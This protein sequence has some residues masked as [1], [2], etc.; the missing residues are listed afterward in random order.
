[1]AIKSLFLLLASIP[2]LK[3]P[4]FQMNTEHQNVLYS[5]KSRFQAFG[6]QMFTVFLVEEVKSR[7]ESNIPLKLGNDWRKALIFS[8]FSII[9]LVFVFCAID[10]CGHGPLQHLALKL[11]RPGSAMRCRWRLKLCPVRTN[12]V[13]QGS[14][15]CH[16]SCHTVLDPQKSDQVFNLKVDENLNHS[17]SKCS[18]I[19]V[20]RKNAKFGY[21]IFEFFYLNFL[22]IELK[23]FIFTY[24]QILR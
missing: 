2:L 6:I 13:W 4:Y 11:E 19:F 12:V 16:G 7:Y 24:C 5:D 10:F 8:M 23:L 17:K 3:Q 18:L 15:G 21:H 1:M 20:Y 9:F 14:L 22:R